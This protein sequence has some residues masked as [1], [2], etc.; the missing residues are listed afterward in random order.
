MLFVK[1]SD[2]TP[3]NIAYNIVNLNL[4]HRQR[5][6]LIRDTPYRWLSVRNKYRLLTHWSYVLLAL[7]HALTGMSYRKY[8]CTEKWAES[9]LHTK[10]WGYNVYYRVTISV[11]LSQG[12][13]GY[14]GTISGDPFRIL[15]GMDSYGNTCH[16]KNRAIDGAQ[17]SGMDMRNKP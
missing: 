17:F 4:E 14:L 2:M 15:Y 13:V 5:M 10:R 12:Y 8:V 16:R 9:R 3:H 6:K 1:P 7:T 11:S